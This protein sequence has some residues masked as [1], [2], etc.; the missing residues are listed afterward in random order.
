LNLSDIDSELKRR[1]ADRRGRQRI[2]AQ[3]LLEKLAFTAREIRMVGKEFVGYPRLL[4]ETSQQI[5]VEFD[6]A[7]RPRE[8]EVV[9]A[10]E[11]L[12]EVPGNGDG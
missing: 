4:R 6:I 12:E 5:G 9:I 8:D 11:T 2:V 1:G 3:S 10:A 7:A